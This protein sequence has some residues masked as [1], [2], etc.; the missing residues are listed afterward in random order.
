MKLKIAYLA[1]W[2]T[3]SSYYRAGGPMEMLARRGH[4]IRQLSRPGGEPDV[5]L[6]SGCDVLLVHRFEEDGAIR[7]MQWAREAGMVVVWD[8]DDDQIAPPPGKAKSFKHWNGYERQEVA[9]RTRRILKLAHVVTTPSRSLAEM[10]SKLGARRVEVLENYLAEVFL[11]A[12]PPPRRGLDVTIGWI[13]AD[14][15]R[16][17]SQTLGVGR[18]LRRLLDAHEGVRVTTVGVDVGIP[19][20]RYTRIKPVPFAELVRCVAGFDVGIAPLADIRFNRARSN[21]KLKEYAALAIPWLASP[22]GPYV[23]MGEEQGGRLVPNDRWFEELEAMVLD[24]G[25]RSRLSERAAHW[26]KREAL[27]LHAPRWERMMLDALA[28][29]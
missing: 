5:S 7:L 8:N 11:A 21:I 18:T 25:T 6:V 4:E 28:R 2:D 1:R 22:I 24:Q 19:S 20:D 14:E 29:T 9:A 26:A 27:H 13:G 16:I 23:G 10:F 12:S 17:D 3:P 15:H